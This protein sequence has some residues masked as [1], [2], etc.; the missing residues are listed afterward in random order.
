MKMDMGGAAAVFGTLQAIIELNL[1]I[2]LVGVVAIV[3]NSIGSNAYRP[4]DIL[5]S[6]NGLSVE[7][8]NTDAEGRLAL[9][10]TLSYV[11]KYDPEVVIDVATLTGGIIVALGNQI[12]GLFSND[13]NL[14]KSLKKSSEEAH[15]PIWHMPLFE[16]YHELLKSDIA[17]INNIGRSGSGASSITAAL[18]LSRFTKKY[19]WAHLD[20]AGTATGNFD[21]TS[22]SGRPVALLTQYLINSCQ[23]S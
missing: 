22:P 17:D 14:I 13:N 2:N 16:E 18:F 9:C 4:G 8:G 19:R 11:E 12:S 15:D 1:P 6:M 10:D 23:K 21:R 3:E 20:I 5:M 7:V